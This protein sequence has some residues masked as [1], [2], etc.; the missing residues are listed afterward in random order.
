MPTAHKR[1][2]NW[3]TVKPK[4]V[5]RSPDEAGFASTQTEVN[6][7]AM[8]TT[9]SGVSAASTVFCTEGNLKPV[10]GLVPVS[11][12][13]RTAASPLKC[14]HR[15][16][17]PV[18]RKGGNQKETTQG[19]TAGARGTTEESTKTQNRLPPFVCSPLRG[20]ATPNSLRE[21]SQVSLQLTAEGSGLPGDRHQFWG[22]CQLQFKRSRLSAAVQRANWN[23]FLRPSIF[24][25]L[26]HDA[27]PRSERISRVP[28]PGRPRLGVI[29]KLEIKH[30]CHRQYQLKCHLIGNKVMDR[31]MSTVRLLSNGSQI[32]RNRLPIVVGRTISIDHDTGGK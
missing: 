7:S 4:A 21:V 23:V 29:V 9:A 19:G 30:E 13:Q 22:W 3:Y 1:P 2:E 12:G 11:D 8:D 18:P 28:P 25:D 16:A 31:K 15:V 24:Y 32:T 20:V 17:L 6:A 5:A 14:G 27:V 26:E 10:L